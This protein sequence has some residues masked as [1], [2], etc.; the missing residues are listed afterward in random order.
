M[1]LDDLALY[2]KLDPGNV[3]RAIDQFA[4]YL[5]NG[6]PLSA[7]THVEAMVATL[8]R[9]AILPDPVTDQGSFNEALVA[10][11]AQAS[12]LSVASP[13]VNNPAKRMA[14]QLIERLPVIHG[15][16]RLLSVAQYWKAR[17][18]SLGKNFAQAEPLTDLAEQSLDGLF[19]PQT[20]TRRIAAVILRAPAGESA[21]EVAHIET[22]RELYMQLGIAVD[23][24]TGRGTNRL[25]QALTLVQY[26]E[27][28]S[29][30]IAI[31]NGVDP[32]SRPATTEFKARMAATSASSN[33]VLSS[34]ENPD[35]P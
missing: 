12:E 34:Q 17:I 32:S 22:A 18:N 6:I 33:Q 10:L 27:Y 7:Q 24:I 13:A 23:V 30:Y 2:E 3:R 29:Y 1:N 26:G 25:A 35:K 11:R 20:L 19:F 31:A 15:E 5:Q 28:V 9:L 8:H 21:E 16:G 4:D 14:G